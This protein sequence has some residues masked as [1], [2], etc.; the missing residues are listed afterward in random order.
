M[1]QQSNGDRGN[2]F[3]NL[4]DEP[5]NE[6]HRVQR[7]KNTKIIYTSPR[8]L[9]RITKIAD[10]EFSHKFETK[11]RLLKQ[12]KLCLTLTAPSYIKSPT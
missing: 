7:V 1:S 3:K 12:R 8:S 2:S 11:R 5:K 6:K 10:I 9:I 4:Y